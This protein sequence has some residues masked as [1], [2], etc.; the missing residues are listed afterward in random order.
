MRER[1]QRVADTKKVHKVVNF[2][3]PAFQYSS[4]LKIQIQFLSLSFCFALHK[5]VRKL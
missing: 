1:A 5:K 3:I 4:V 2:K